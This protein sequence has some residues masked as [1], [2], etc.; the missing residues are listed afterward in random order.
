M[1]KMVVSTKYYDILGVSPT[2]SADDIKRSYKKLALKYHPDKNP[3]GSDKFK[4]ITEAYEILGDAEKRRV[5]DMTGENTQQPRDDL[6]SRMF[7]AFNDRQSMGSL[8]I[9]YKLGLT[10]AQIITGVTKTI[11]YNRN[12]KCSPCNGQGGS[13]LST[14]PQ[15]GGSGFV[16]RMVNMMI[17]VT[18]TQVECQRCRGRGKIPS[19]P[20]VK[21]KGAGTIIESKNLSVTIPAGVNNGANLIIEK[22][23]H[24]DGIHWGNVVIIVFQE[25]HPTYKR[26][27]NDLYTKL[28]I[29]LN[30]ALCGGFLSV[31]YVTGKN[32]KARIAGA[33]S[34]DIKRIR[35]QGING[36]DLLIEVEIEFP[37]LSLHQKEKLQEIL[38]KPKEVNGEYEVVTLE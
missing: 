19:N 3:Q 17:M 12:T 8:N 20:C 5:Y 26:T 11:V 34:G 9:N 25:P 37:Q 32:L 23:G 35:K 38:G 4:E 2:A 14:C 29:P 27:G 36:G 21:C 10:L 1:T 16:T 6:F 13:N 22:E 24:S 7:N 33:K 28:T 31:P 15:C 30:L 18:T